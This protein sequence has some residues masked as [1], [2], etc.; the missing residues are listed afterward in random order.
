MKRRDS[1]GTEADNTIA[2]D[3]PSFK[4]LLVL[5]TAAAFMLVAAT[6][7]NTEFGSLTRSRSTIDPNFNIQHHWNDFNEGIPMEY[8][9]RFSYVGSMEEA[10]YLKQRILQE[11]KDKKILSLA[12]ERGLLSKLIAIIFDLPNILVIVSAFLAKNF[13]KAIIIAVIAALIGET[14]LAA[15]KETYDITETFNLRVL[16]YM[17]MACL[18]Y[19]IT[20]K[21]IKKAKTAAE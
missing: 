10:Q 21:S 18:I 16:S 20:S 11:L 7:M 9:R 2:K 17:A 15:T 5:L 19:W 4:I 6:I 13:W 3:I 12:G 1:V 14:M 8:W